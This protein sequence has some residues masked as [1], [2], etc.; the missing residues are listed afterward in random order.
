LINNHSNVFTGQNIGNHTV[1]PIRRLIK[2][3]NEY[4]N[5]VKLL[6]AKMQQILSETSIYK[7]SIEEQN[8]PVEILPQSQNCIV[9]YDGTLLLKID[10]IQSR[11]SE[12]YFSIEFFF[13]PFLLDDDTKSVVTSSP[14]YTSPDGYKMCVRLY[15]NG[16]GIAQSTHVS[17]FLIL[18]RGDYDAILKWPFNFQVIF[19]LYDVINQK[20]H[21]IESFQSNTKLISFLRPRGEMNIGSGIPKFIPRSAI[22]QNNNLYVC[23]DSIYIK[24]MVRKNVIP[25]SILPDVMCIDPAL[26]VYMQE[27]IIQ[28]KINKNKM[29]PFKLTLTLRLQQ[30]V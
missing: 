11:L 19:C 16:N 26:P 24:V 5:N 30:S 3:F 21:I 17:I 18:L 28:N 4:S 27:E 13:M 1:F 15:F 2:N 14:F 20:N 9:P 29:Q 23:D 25:P 7:I 22:Q 8:P 6:K 10:N 12:Q